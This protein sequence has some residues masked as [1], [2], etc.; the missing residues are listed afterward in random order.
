MPGLFRPLIKRLHTKRSNLPYLYG[1]LERHIQLDEKE[2]GP[3]AIHMVQ[4]LCDGSSEK[5]S[6]VVEVAEQA[7]AARLDFWDGIDTA[8][9]S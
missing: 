2:H 4:E 1:Y 8:L 3:I 9:A 7:L 5:L 6:E